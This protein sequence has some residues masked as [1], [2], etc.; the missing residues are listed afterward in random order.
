MAGYAAAGL[1]S[2]II[3]HAWITTYKLANCGEIV[4]QRF[5][6]GDLQ[7]SS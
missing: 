2:A 7:M 4:A 3:F 1:V 5:V 6:G